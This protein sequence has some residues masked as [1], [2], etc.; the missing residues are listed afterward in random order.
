MSANDELADELKELELMRL[1]G[2]LNNEWEYNFIESVYAQ[3]TAGRSLSAVQV[4]KIE[5]I[6]DR[7]NP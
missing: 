7:H 6:Y 5:E 4:E 3:F 1:D 2:D